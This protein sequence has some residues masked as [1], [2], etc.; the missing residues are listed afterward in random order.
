MNE[1]LERRLHRLSDNYRRIEADAYL[2]T[3]IMTQVN[4]RRSDR[5]RYGLWLA[6]AT[7]A[8][9]I[10]AITLLP[11]RWDRPEPERRLA[12]SLPAIPGWSIQTP[13][14]PPTKLKMPN[15]SQL[16]RLPVLPQTP[17]HKDDNRTDIKRKST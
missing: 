16:G 8:A 13:T 10:A 1:P 4:R 15:L 14:A 6:G 5:P 7:I 17:D 11:E 2:T 12:I 3:R 9:V